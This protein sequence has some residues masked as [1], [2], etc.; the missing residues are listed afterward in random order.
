MTTVIER[1]SAIGRPALFDAVGNATTITDALLRTATFQYDSLNRQTVSINALARRTTSSFDAVGNLT[2][3]ADARTNLTTY[4]YDALN[5]QT[6]WIDAL[7]L[8]GTTSYD[9]A[10]NITLVQDALNRR[11]TYLYDSADRLTVVVDA[12][13]FRATSAYDAA[14]NLTLAT[15]ARNNATTYQYDALNR[16]TAVIDALTNRTTSA[17]DAAGN[18]TQITDARGSIGTYLYDALNRNTVMLNALAGRTTMAFDAVGNL[19][20]LTDVR[21]NVSTYQFD[22]L[23][24]QTVGIDAL[25]GRTTTGYDAVGNVTTSTDPLNHTTSFLYDAANQR[26]VWIDALSNRS[27]SAYDAVGNVTEIIDARG[28][29]TTYLYDAIQRQTAAVDALSNRTTSAYDAVGNLTK[30][31]DA[32]SNVTT[33]AFDALD[34]QTVTIDSLSR[35][36]TLAFDAVG[37]LTTVTDALSKVT[38]YAYDALSRQTLATD[39]LGN[40][41]TTSYDAVGNAT[42]VIDPVSHRTTFSFNALNRQTAILDALGGRTTLQFDAAG[43]L[44]VLI[45]P[46]G[47]RTTSAFD[48]VNRE[49]RRND[50]LNDVATYA[51]DAAGLLTS[52]TDRIGRRKDMSYDNGNRLTGE[53]WVTSGSPVNT[54][55]YSYD[56]NGNLLTAAEADGTITLAY[57]AVNRLTVQ[58]DVFGVTSTFAYDQ[59]GN[60]T[61]VQDSLN[62]VA[63]STYNAVNLLTR[64]EFNDGTTPLRIDLAYTDRNELSLITRY[65]DLAGSS[66]VG[67][68]SYTYDDAGR[69]TRIRHR[70]A[71]D[72]VFEDYQYSF[73]AASRMLTEKINAGT[74][75]TFT[76][77]DTDQLT[78]ATGG[79]TES[80]DYDLNGNRDSS[81]YTTG[82]GNRITNDGVYTYSYDD[83]GNITKRSKG[84]SL[85]TWTYGYDHLNHQ[86]WVEK[87][88]SD[89][90]T[91]QLRI[92]DD[93]DAFGQRIVQR[94]DSDGNGS[95]NTTEKFAFTD[96]MAWADLDGSSNLTMRRLH[97]DAVDQ[98]FAHIS[99]GGSAAWYLT[100][101]LGSPTQIV[102]NS[103]TI[104]DTITYDSFGAPTDSNAANGDRFKFT[105]QEWTA[106]AETYLFDDRTV[107]PRIGRFMQEDRVRADRNNLF[108]YVGNNPLVNTD[109]TG[110]NA[111]QMWKDLSEQYG[112]WQQRHGRG[113][114][115]TDRRLEDAPLLTVM[116]NFFAYAGSSTDATLA[117]WAKRAFDL[118]SGGATPSEIQSQFSAPTENVPSHTIRIGGLSFQQLILAS[119]GGDK[120][121][122]WKLAFEMSERKGPEGEYGARVFQA[123]QEGILPEE[124][125]FGLGV[126]DLKLYF[127]PPEKRVKV[128]QHSDWYWVG[129][130]IKEVGREIGR[131]L[132]LIEPADPLAN[133]GPYDLEARRAVLMNILNERGVGVLFVK[134]AAAFAKGFLKGFFKDGL[135][136]SVSDLIGLAKLGYRYSP[137][138]FVQTMTTGDRYAAEQKFITEGKKML[139]GVGEFLI[140]SAAKVSIALEAVITGKNLAGAQDV[141]NHG[142]LGKAIRAMEPVLIEIA[143]AATKDETK[144]W[145]S[146]FVL[147]QVVEEVVVGFLTAGVGNLAKSA[148]TAVKIVS[149]LEK[150]MPDTGFMRSALR[151]LRNVFLSA[152]DDVHDA[153][154]LPNPHPGKV[155]LQMIPGQTCFAAGTPLL[156]PDGSKPIEQFQLGDWILSRDENNVNGPVECKRV[157]EVFRRTANLWRVRV[158]GREIVATT[159]EHPFYVLRKG[160]CCTSELM[161]GDRLAS[162]NEV[163]GVVEKVVETGEVANVYNLR[164]ADYH[165]YFVCERGWGFWVRGTQ[166]GL[167][168]REARGRRLDFG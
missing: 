117:D 76:H 30:L 143:I 158:S 52:M 78:A 155:P 150:A 42:V 55:A 146:G 86:I 84:A 2:Q 27:T 26:T 125:I 4:L 17:Y 142:V 65:S 123:L 92:E 126:P 118:F 38:T 139:D 47:N 90:G 162:H 5:R 113:P 72:A 44:T 21:N 133:A 15:D 96:R 132:G 41:T 35:R 13:N 141:W 127:V 140:Q 11:T 18:V 34:R 148:K 147:Y 48:A 1:G 70:D 144:G 8:R 110:N 101:F 156:T 166:C 66:K 64:R 10:G 168:D 53:T 159:G 108:R 82:T 134:D 138:G 83:E 106:V 40:K 91:L 23:N 28:N 37:N 153:G 59:V 58:T 77:D 94:I 63:T 74:T 111:V 69:N 85:E 129:Q 119:F 71:V 135:A 12:L 50:P 145:A 107:L 98:L 124:I 6:A 33:Y 163:T 43:N 154:K 131:D 79:K 32:R 165:S 116:G 57:D 22:A 39:P 62:G 7:S 105:G 136:G 112:N 130:G 16:L 51:Y 151:K 157:E 149:K 102:N 54:F 61:R 46:L 95:W 109:P 103:G 167:Q 24:R 19:T 25:N 160:W 60:R 97:G 68:T 80:Y 31:T 164:I 14:D 45:D 93:Y 104:L 114:T 73:D 115:G 122:V 120:T 20:K 99:S 49:T 3:L 9:A 121:A 137:L 152:A 89:G 128:D 100:D 29:R 81:G 88:A 161:P 67:S 36:T 87:R 56:P 75:T